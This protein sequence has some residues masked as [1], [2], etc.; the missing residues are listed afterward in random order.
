M[1][2]EQIS[3]RVYRVEKDTNAVRM[4]TQRKLDGHNRPRFHTD[5]RARN[6]VTIR[7]HTTLSNI[8]AAIQF[9]A[10]RPLHSK[11]DLTDGY[12]NIRILPDSEKDTTFFSPMAHYQSR[13]M[14]QGDCN[15]RAIMVR[16]MKD[17]F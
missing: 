15:G 7:N 8:E 11:I 5:C 12:H 2:S 13:V 6:V 4:F 1:N 10:V 17:I 9:I 14:Q 3:R 16:A